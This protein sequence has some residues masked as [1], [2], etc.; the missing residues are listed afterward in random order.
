MTRT[1]S[2][3]AVDMIVVLQQFIDGVT[4]EY[5]DEYL[6]HH[7][8]LESK[9]TKKGDTWVTVIVFINDN[10]IEIAKFNTVTMDD[11]AVMYEIIT[12]TIYNYF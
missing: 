5:E 2:K 8:V 11:P 4:K 12:S 3:M 1:Y 9:K 7:F 10:P 6:G